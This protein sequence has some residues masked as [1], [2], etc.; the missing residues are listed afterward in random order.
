MKTKTLSLVLALALVVSVLSSGSRSVGAQT[1]SSRGSATVTVGVPAPIS[2]F[3]F[4][5]SD[6]EII[7]LN[8]LQIQSLGS[9]SVPTVV[10]AVSNSGG[11]CQKFLSSGAKTVCPLSPS[12]LYSIRV[13]SETTLLQKNRSRASFSQFQ[14]GDTIN[15]YGFRDRDTGNLDALILR[16]LSIPKQEKYI[17]LNNVQVVSGPSSTLPPATIV[18]TRSGYPCYDYGFSGTSVRSSMVCPMGFTDPAGVGVAA[19][20]AIDPM[21]YPQAKYVIQITSTTAL[22]NK[23]WGRIGLAPI[24]VGDS[25]NVYGRLAADGVTVA[26]ITLR[27]LSLPRPTTPSTLKISTSSELHTRVG[28][29]F[30]AGFDVSGSDYAYTI[31]TEGS[32]AIPGMYFT[33]TR[34]CPTGQYCIQVLDQDSVYLAGTP[35]V[36]GKYQVVVSAHDNPP[37]IYCITT[38]CPQLQTKYGK[39]VFTLIVEPTQSTSHNA[40]VIES[41]GGP[42]VL[43]VGETGSFTITAR[44]PEGGPLSYSVRWGDEPV[45]M[46][47]PSSPLRMPDETRTTA[48]LMHA[49]SYPGTYTMYFTVTDTQGLSTQTT[50]SVNVR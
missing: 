9:G 3:D 46:G 33:Q 8:N 26:A 35:T 28:A 29:S 24:Q 44:D 4:D 48:G 22:Y 40:P 14:V 27:D 39:A 10:T 12:Y 2:S 47:A 19:N 41:V 15:V 7:Q 32:D 11:S 31:S 30:T 13:S 50:L 21:Y 38:P 42:S 25:V 5:R 16:D 37:Q 20:I 23:T 18:V 6:D 36:A 1:D 49:Y 43:T 34:P 17:Q 45:S